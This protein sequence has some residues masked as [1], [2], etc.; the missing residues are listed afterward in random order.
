MGISLISLVVVLGVLIFVHEAGHFLVARLFGV[1]VEKFSLGFGP[2][3]FGKT[4]GRTDYRVSAIPLGG[5]VKMVGEDPDCELPPEDLPVS[6]THKNVYQ[7]MAIVAAGPVFNL[8]LAVFIFFAFMSAFGMDGIR[9]VVR[10]V[11]PESPAA[12]VGF[13]VED[14]IVAIDGHDAES[15]F[16]VRRALKGSDGEPLLFTVERGGELLDLKAVPVLKTTRDILGDEVEYYDLGIS[17]WPLIEAVIGEVTQGFPA[18][19]AGLRAGDRIATI[20]GTSV[21]SWEQMRKAIAAADKNPLRLKIQRGGSDF[22]VEITPQLAVQK[23]PAGNKVER[24]LIGISSGKPS[25][26]EELR[27]RK[28]LSPAAAFTESLNRTWMIIDLTFRGISKMLT[29]TIS[30][31]NLGGPIMIAQMAGQQAKQSIGS[32]IYFM[33][34]ISINLAILNFLPI[35]VLDGGHLMFFFIEAVLGRPVNLRIRE[36]ATQTGMFILLALMIFVTWNDI[37]RN[38]DAIIKFFTRIFTI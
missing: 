34:F 2:R 4:V 36:I 28:R 14:R 32:L 22:E 12:Q 11:A 31:N 37:A 23:D 21:N 30:S 18:E 35:P 16:D 1:G 19:K 8:L 7:R 29:G 6:F 25:V 17:E 38:S 5:Y 26:P 13:Q 10:H 27:I 20:N 33:A 3:I 15:W 24:R 9:S